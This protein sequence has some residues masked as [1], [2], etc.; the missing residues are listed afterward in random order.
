MTVVNAKDIILQAAEG[1]YA[2]RN[3]NITNLI[4]VCTRGNERSANA[5]AKGML[6]DINFEFVL[7]GDVVSKKK[8][9]PKSIFS[10]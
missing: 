6:G 1:K 7:V 10:F 2:V 4:C 8:P 5:I 3:F 9:D